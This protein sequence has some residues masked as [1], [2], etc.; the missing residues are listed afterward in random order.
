MARKR[1]MTACANRWSRLATL[2][3]LNP[4]KRPNSYLAWTD[5]GDAARVEDRTF[6]CTE[7]KADAGPNNNWAAPAEMRATL[8]KLLD[9]AT[10]AARCTSCRSPWA[11]WARR[12]SHIGVERT[13]SLYVVASMRIMTRMGS[14]VKRHPGRRRRVRALRPIPRARRWLAARPMRRG[15]AIRPTTSS[16]I[17]PP[18][19]IWSYGSGYGRQRAAG[20]EVLRAAYRFH[21][22]T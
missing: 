15:P 16:T 18:R 11:R 6:I 17:R 3:R 10:R 2:R 22:G 21:D 4:K 5:P 1:N 8:N 14:K 9:G 7:D 13:D 19:E 12:F 20:Q